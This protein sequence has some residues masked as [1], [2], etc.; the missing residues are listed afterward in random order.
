MKP[1]TPTFYSL[2][3]PQMEIWFD[4]ILRPDVP[5]YNIG[6]YLRIEGQI[7]I[8]LFEQALN[9]VIQDNDALR[10]TFFEGKM[11]PVQNLV[12]NVRIKLDFCDCSVEEN[13]HGQALA[14][15][16]QEFVKPFKLY[17]QFLFR[18]A[19]YKISDNCYYWLQKYHS[20]TVD[21][22]AISL[23]V[24][25]VAEIY[26][27][28][29]TGQPYDEL[30]HYSYWDF[31][32]NDQTYWNSEEFKQQERYWLE[33]Y[34]QLPEPLV[35]PQ[36]ASKFKG[37]T[38]PS[39][40]STLSI[41]GDFYAQISEFYTANHTSIF[42]VILGVLYCYFVRTGDRHDLAIGLTSSNRS[43][44]AFKQTIGRFASINQAW[45]GFGSDLSFVKLLEAIGSELEKDSHNQRFPIC[46]INKQIG[47]DQNSRN[48]VFDIMLSHEKYENDVHFNGNPAFAISLTNGFEQNALA[49]FIREFCRDQYAQVDFDYNLKAFEADE[50]ERIKERFEFLLTELLH[51][52]DVPLW[53]LQIVPEAELKTILFDFNDTAKDYPVDQCIHQLFEAQVER[54]PNAVAAVFEGQQLTYAVLNNKANQLAHYLQTLGVKPEVLVGI[55]VERSLKMIIALLGILKAGGAYLPLDHTYPEARVAFMLE[56]AQVPV[57]LSQASLKEQLPQTSAKIIC[58]D[59]ETQIFS[60]FSQENPRSSVG[61]DNLAYVI[62]TSGSTGKPKGI[63]IEHRNTVTLLNWAKDVF[64]AEEIEG[65]LASTSVCFDLSLFEIFV[66]LSWGGTMILVENILHQPNI[67]N[68]TKITLINTVPS[69]I[70]E[71]V[72][73]GDIPASVSVV[74]LAGEALKNELVQQIYQQETIQKV[75]NLYGPSEDT[76]YSTFDLVEKGNTRPTT[77]GSPIANSQ[78][79]ILDSHLQP[80]PIGV[81]G[82]LHISGAGLARG[83][84]N[85]PELTAQKF[86]FD[87]FS[88]VPKAHLYKTGDLARYQPNGIIEYLGRMDNQVKIRGFR[89]ELG[90]IETSINQNPTI[91]ESVVV[92][93][94]ASSNKHLV[95]YC[96]PQEDQA[97]DSTLLS[98]C[99]KERLPDYMIPSAFVQIDAIPLTPNGKVDRRTLQLSVVSHPL[100]ENGLIKPRTPEEELVAKIWA[101]I[102]GVEQVG[103]DDNFFEFGGNSLL[104]T[105]IISRIQEI[106]EVK[107]PIHILLEKPTVADIGKAVKQIRQSI[108]IADNNVVDLNAEAVLDYAIQPSFVKPESILLTGATGFLGGNLLYELLAQT[109]AN[110]YCL[111]RAPNTNKGKNELQKKLESYSLWNDSFLP[112]IIPVVG[113]LSKPLLGMPELQFD[114]FA[115]KIDVIYHNGAMVNYLY[116]YSALKSTNVLGTQEVLRLANQT[117]IKSVHFIS[118][119]DVLSCYSD[120]IKL[121]KESDCLDGEEIVKNGYAQ[122][123]WVAEKLVRSAAK[124]GLPVCIYRL[125]RI[126]GHSKTGVSNINDFVNLLIKSCIQLGKLP[127]LK[128]KEQNMMPIDYVSRTIV[129]FSQQVDMLGKTFHLLNPRS[130][131][132]RELSDWLR[133]LGYPLELILPEQWLFELK[134][135]KENVLYPLLPVLYKDGFFDEK[136][137]YVPQFDCQNTLDGLAGTDIV[138]PPINKELLDT[139]FSYFIKE[140]FLEAPPP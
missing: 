77:I 53:Q 48:Q 117:K 15:M 37:Q 59:D 61:P 69:G 40:R 57:L 88:E 8:T 91:Q 82:E 60:Q 43:T 44:A 72:R 14:R 128:R 109:T 52:P 135:Q 139:Y 118:T 38:P 84:L 86:I 105:Q 93:H 62:Y 127:I 41:K 75:F 13:A 63:M 80:V 56:D 79:Y 107:L 20:L 108:N 49:I 116:P 17:D 119:I 133:S 125:G 3:S 6:G 34:R 124:H 11:L 102:L 42:Q 10:I 99:L 68:G 45:L 83:Y 65:V 54:T 33:K 114:H 39:Q 95:A 78:V 137:L 130:T 106:C 85:R 5:L 104:A 115:S 67:S 24:Q 121:M 19:L 29:F 74:N 112:R 66:P 9:Q 132:W 110:I 12:E 21:D 7:K 123:K 18:F 122:S 87:P 28:L 58:L 51:H 71:L 89:I 103:V 92:V 1:N 55:C 120:E 31:I 90:E 98:A 96:V 126:A 50:I 136:Q 47:L 97:I 16:E 64:T 140:G 131:L 27:A 73:M 46:E 94:G 113:D 76:T 26:N 134:H 23:I 36:Y 111:V 32:K 22:R 30:T 138:C 70:A 4:Q 81:S 129:H 25:Q 101:D 100:E 35:V 2:S